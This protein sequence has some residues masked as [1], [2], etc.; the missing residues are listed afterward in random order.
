MAP[1]ALL[2]SVWL[3]WIGLL[4]ATPASSEAAKPRASSSDLLF[5]IG[6]PDGRAAEFGLVREGYAAFREKF[7]GPVVYTVGKSTARDWPFIHPGPRDQWAGGR[8][9]TLTINF[10]SPRDE[11]RPLYLILG[12]AGAHGSERSKVVVAVN[13][14][15]LPAQVAP[16]GPP[17]LVSNPMQQGTPQTMTFALPLDA[18]HE[19]E[20]SITIRL[21]GQSWILY[22]YV[23]LSTRLQAP[24]PIAPE[25]RDLLTEFRKGP[26]AGVEE[27]VFAVRQPGKDGHWYANFGYYSNTQLKE[28]YF[29]RY[30][31]EGKRLTYGDGGRLC[32]LNLRT[33]EVKLLLDDPKGGVR[34]P[35]VH[36]DARKV[37][38][39]YRPGGT[40]NYHLYEVN[41]DGTGLRQ[42]TD[43]PFD[44]IEPTYLPDGDILFVSS[45]CK[46]WV[47]CWVTQVAVLH[48]CDADGGRIRALS[49]NNEHDNT[50]WVLPSGQIL[51]TRWEYVDRNQV[52]YHHLWIASPDGTHQTVYFGNMHA[53]T[54]M[55]DAKP[56]P[57]S[58]KV[59]ASF[60]PGHGQR[61]HDGVITV[62]DP[63]DGPDNP[64]SARPISRQA[65]FRD[66]W[67]FSEDAF[68]AARGTQIVLIDGDGQTQVIYEL[69]A[70]EVRAG[71]QCH[72]PR[73]LV[74]RPRE[75]V[76]PNQVEWVQETGWLLLVDAYRG[77]N[78]AGVKRG[79]IKKLLVLESLP[80]PINFT[81][82]MEPL[83]YGGTFTLERVLGTIP[84]EPDGSAY[85]EL[86]ALRSLILVALDENDLSVKRMQSFLTVMPGETTTCVGC[87]EQ[88]TTT[89]QYRSGE[90]LAFRRGPSHVEP[91]AGAPEVLDFPRDVQPILDKHCLACHD[92]Q[93]T[94]QG[95][96]RAGGVIL[97]GDRG[98]MFSISYYTLTARSLVADGR[99]GPGNRSP[100]SIGS[101]A[102]RLMK[103]M[104]GTHY[105]VK[106]PDT[107]RQIVR[108]W[109]EAG[110]AYPGTY[111][112]LGCGMIGGYAENRL[113]RSD[114]KWP[115]VTASMDVL[116]R[117]CGQCHKGPMAL[118]LSPSDEIGGPP[119]VDLGANDLRRR[120]ARH[121][122]YNLSRPEKSLLLLA[123]LSKKAGGYESCGKAIFADTADADYLAVLLAI[124]D[125]RKKLDEVKRFDM[126]GFRPRP[127]YLREMKRYGILP[128]EWAGDGPLDMYQ[129]EQKYWQSLWHRSMAV[130]P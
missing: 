8:T 56:I 71:L 25:P 90:L 101:S 79:D 70:P 61:E 112:A 119:W 113:D 17:D 62:L 15:P 97:S 109:I 10:A 38:F 34:D 108:L 3:F 42:L 23:A 36:Y 54:T 30:A 66:P 37:L 77:R 21:D 64:R 52:T 125:A 94:V 86:P 48:R 33:K 107:Q 129:L 111:A 98:P 4:A 16:A 82:G 100:R 103:L 120:W 6:M 78:M 60:S 22:D 53:G 123:P 55:I 121:L 13:G 130:G 12:L 127:E 49:S 106:L 114:M 59:V 58:R 43:G 51:Y 1:R 2:K 20:N 28:T 27:I 18:V 46:R 5:C 68:L 89:P 65:N 29:D 124:T 87:H 19:G 75:R 126:P 11:G 115:S 7:P 35:I 26:M 91:I 84:V 128:A 50:P 14:N 41:L 74:V 85:A 116:K 57:G 39:S 92:Y 45:R 99:N 117:R 122:L 95:G 81:G 24:K 83:S 63:R 80:K 93:P 110:A 32:R 96:P 31:K 73:P 102:S 40:E 105:G 67:A 118:P 76:V 69:P 44:D 88:R 9:H 104:D 47:N 72:E